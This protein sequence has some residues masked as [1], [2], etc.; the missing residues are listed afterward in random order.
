[1]K[2]TL[3]KKILVGFL[4]LGLMLPALTLADDDDHDNRRS[5][6]LQ[7]TWF[8]VASPEITI[9]TGW[10]VT[11]TGKSRNY[12]TNNL[13]YPAYFDATLSFLP[14][15]V[16]ASF[17]DAH[18]L[19]TLRGTWERTGPHSFVYSFTG[20]AVAADNFTPVWV[21][22]VSGTI[23]LSSDCNSEEIT[24]SLEVFDPS[25]SPFDGDPMFP[26]IPLP[27]HYGHRANAN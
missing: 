9:L 2:T 14:F 27:T 26:A 5:C 6:S 8:G 16:P 13:E 4:S 18:H 7:G 25:V 3:L 15:P 21:G 24:A 1:M 20:M 22:N 23:E 10:V 19:S 17:A 11:A 12:G